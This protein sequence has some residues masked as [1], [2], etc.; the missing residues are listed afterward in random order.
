MNIENEYY[1]YVYIDPRDYREFY[2]GKGKGN[3]KE[4]HLSDESDSVKAAQIREIL[5]QGEQPIIR[6]IAANLTES[7]AFLI[8]KTLIWKLG[9][10]LTN[11]ASGNFSEK[12]RP[13]KSIHKKLPGF[14][15]K[16]NVYHFNTGE[17]E[18]HLNWDNCF[19]L[20]CLTAGGG[21]RWMRDISDLE[22]GDIIASYVSKYGYVGIGKVKAKARPIK[23][24]YISNIPV[25]AMDLNYPK[26]SKDIDDYE[27]CEYVA[28]VDWIKGVEDKKDAKPAKG[29]YVPQGTKASL[30][31]QTK[32]LD[33]LETEFE[34]DFEDL[35]QDSLTS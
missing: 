11:K 19:K 7:E 23:E 29:L 26:Q 10:T 32:S 4:S 21:K 15:F 3:R 33:F 35:L 8:E 6:V 25:I 24:V 20:G 2:Y 5:N 30:W 22:V 17:A 9:H 18:G 27:K 16:N 12:F 28:L 1:V 31:N 34:V 14:D 13:H